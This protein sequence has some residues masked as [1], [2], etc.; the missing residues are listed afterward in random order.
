MN[1][2]YWYLYI[3]HQRVATHPLIIGMNPL[4]YHYISPLLWLAERCEPFASVINLALIGPRGFPSLVS[5]FPYLKPLLKSSGCANRAL[6]AFTG[7][8]L[9]ALGLP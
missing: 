4:C 5:R 8:S 3:V 1:R 2:R 7:H 6:I 9:G